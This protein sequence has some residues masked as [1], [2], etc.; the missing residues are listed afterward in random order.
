MRRAASNASQADASGEFSALRG[1]RKCIVEVANS[2]RDGAARPS[3]ML[4]AL[5]ECAS[6]ENGSSAPLRAE[7]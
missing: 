4:S 1:S 6:I 5:N 7:Q 2:G 3:L